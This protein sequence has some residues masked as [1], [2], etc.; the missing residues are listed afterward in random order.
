[1]LYAQKEISPD[2]C[3][4]VP[5]CKM[6]IIYASDLILCGM[7]FEEQL[8]E[9]LSCLYTPNNTY[10]INSIKK[11]TNTFKAMLTEVVIKFYYPFYRTLTK[12]S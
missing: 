2:P 5:I 11:K 1:M 6:G 3:L 9:P 4:Q 10:Y 7:H 12:G 8:E